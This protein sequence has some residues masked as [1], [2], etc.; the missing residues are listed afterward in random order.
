MDG[1]EFCFLSSSSSSP[2]LLSGALL[3][4]SFA[5]SPSS[6]PLPLLLPL[7]SRPPLSLPLRPRP[8]P[9]SE[10]KTSQDAFDQDDAHQARAGQEAEAEPAHPL[11]DPVRLPRRRARRRR[12]RPRRHKPAALDAA[13][14]HAE[15]ARWQPGSAERNCCRPQRTCVFFRPGRRRGVVRGAEG[16]KRERRRERARSLSLSFSCP[17]LAQKLHPSPPLFRRP[18]PHRPCLSS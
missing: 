15:R 17:P 18:S 16:G 2:K 11:L 10:R 12:R 9:F 14:P 1:S 7:S 13:A 8:P 3:F 4:F 5:S 6:S